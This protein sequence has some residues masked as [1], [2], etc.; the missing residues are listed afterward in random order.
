[1]S[2]SAVFNVDANLTSS[3]GFKLNSTSSN[4][5]GSVANAGDMNGDGTP[6][7]VIGAHVAKT[8]YVVF[9]SKSGFATSFNVDSPA[10]NGTNGFKLT[11]FS[12]I[13]GGCVASVGDINA[14]G[15][16]D[17]AIG[18]AMNARIAYVVFGSKSGFA[19]SFNVDSPALDGTNGF[20]LT[21]SS[22]SGFGQSATSAGD[23][24]GDALPDIVIGAGGAAY[25]VFGNKQTSPAPA[26]QPTNRLLSKLALSINAQGTYGA[27]GRNLFKKVEDAS[28]GVTKPDLSSK[29][30]FGRKS[31]LTGSRGY[32]MMGPSESQFGSS[33]SHGGDINGECCRGFVLNSNSGRFA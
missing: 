32:N 25:V 21:S 24:N 23:L 20:K 18:T 1:M 8:A 17:I 4:F 27:L 10:L 13:F 5:G 16:D 2:F 7:I 19:P 33:V 12:S 28:L 11:S 31:N 3:N 22:S 15:I 26:P 9:G 29:V 6:D 30:E 14:D